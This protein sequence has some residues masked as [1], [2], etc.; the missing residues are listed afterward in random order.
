MEESKEYVRERPICA[1]AE[2]ADWPEDEEENVNIHLLAREDLDDKVVHVWEEIEGYLQSNYAR[3]LR[4]SMTFV[5]F[6]K[7]ICG[8]K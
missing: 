6:D 5:E 7:F 8:E 4:G 1:A 3:N 2:E